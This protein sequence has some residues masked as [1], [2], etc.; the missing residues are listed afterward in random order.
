MQ[1]LIVLEGGLKLEILYFNSLDSTQIYLK[2]KIKSLQLQEP[3]AILAK[4]QLSGLGSRDN[5]WNSRSGDLFLSFAVALKS[6]PKDLHL[7]SSSI[8][9]SFLMKKVLFKY[10]TNIWLKWPND[11]YI[12]EKKVGGVITSVVDNI[13]ICGIGVNII[14][15]NDDLGFLDIDLTPQ[16]I[17]KLYLEE[18]E[19]F[20]TRKQIFSDYKIEFEKSRKYYTNINGS[21]ISLERS[22]LQ[23]DGSLLLDGKKVYSLR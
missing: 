20:P 1:K 16:D 10:N 17:S 3:I 12:E 2:D 11:L 4:E 19:K 6:L 14:N 22:I 18:V 9:F 8:Y 15:H 13:L 7:S 5:S 23:E 21:Y